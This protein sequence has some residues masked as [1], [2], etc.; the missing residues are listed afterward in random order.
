MVPD[1]AVGIE[2]A[3]GHRH[4]PSLE[5]LAIRA[6]V[7]VFSSRTASKRALTNRRPLRAMKLFRELQTPDPVRRVRCSGRSCS[8]RRKKSSRGRRANS[9]ALRR[10]IVL[11]TR[12]SRANVCTLSP[13]EGSGTCVT[14][15]GTRRRAL[16]AQP[17]PD[18]RTSRRRCQSLRG[19]C[20]SRR[21]IRRS[22]L[23]ICA[24]ARAQ[25]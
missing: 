15:C 1:S 18:Y 6:N 3:S 12:Y 7:D 21:P 8:S 14:A 9:R 5:S 4:L 19:R 20:L 16:R 13:K 25:A 17:R 2:V 22:V 11:L 10:I 23:P 24:R